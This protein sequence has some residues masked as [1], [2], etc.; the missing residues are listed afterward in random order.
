MNFLNDLP[1]FYKMSMALNPSVLLEDP[2]TIALGALAVSAVCASVLYEIVRRWR[3]SV[4]QDSA[5]MEL[6][7]HKM[8]RNVAH[9]VMNSPLSF[10]KFTTTT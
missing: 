5:D 3:M 9:N 10:G 6:D 1:Q 8:M 2:I 7:K 4:V